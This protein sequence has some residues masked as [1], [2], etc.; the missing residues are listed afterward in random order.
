MEEGEIELEEGF[1]WRSSQADRMYFSFVSFLADLGRSRDGAAM[2]VW[3]K[4]T[5]SCQ[6]AT[7]AAMALRTAC[8]GI[9]SKDNTP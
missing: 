1:G 7:A 3:D 4:E 5:W 6:K 9:P 8:S 2:P